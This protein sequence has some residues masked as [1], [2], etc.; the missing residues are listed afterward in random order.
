MIQC[1]VF[2]IEEHTLKAKKEKDK[3]KIK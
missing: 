3:S 2:G 1:D